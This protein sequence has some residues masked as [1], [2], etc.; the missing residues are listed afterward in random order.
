MQQLK[1]RRFEK[2]LKEGLKDPHEDE[3]ALKQLALQE[4]EIKKL[5][6]DL[7]FSHHSDGSYKSFYVYYAV[8][9]FQAFRCKEEY[10]KFCPNFVALFKRAKKE[11]KE[12]PMLSRA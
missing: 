8:D 11:S 10:L 5:P 7:L 6:S 3:L 9:N 12:I 2:K 4:E 1:M